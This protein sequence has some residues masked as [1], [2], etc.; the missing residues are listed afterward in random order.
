M[1]INLSAARSGPYINFNTGPSGT[2]GIRQLSLSS[3]TS[4]LAPQPPAPSDPGT[5]Q[6]TYTDND[7]NVFVWDPATSQFVPAAGGT[8]SSASSPAP[9]PAPSGPSVPYPGGPFPIKTPTP[10]PQTGGPPGGIGPVDPLAATGGHQPGELSS[11][12]LPSGYIQDRE[13]KKYADGSYNWVP[14]GSPHAPSAA[15]QP[16]TPRVD[17][18]AQTTSAGAAALNAQTAAQRAAAEAQAAQDA[19]QFKKDQAGIDNAYRDATQK[20]H[21]AI[22]ARDFAAAEHWKQVAADLNQ[23]QFDLNDR[24]Q[25]GNLRNQTTGLYGFDENGRPTLDTGRVTGY[26]RMPDGSVVSTLDRQLGEANSRRQDVAINLNRQQQAFNQEQAQREE[27]IKL[28]LNP[29]TALE[30]A[31]LHGKGGVV[32]PDTTFG[33]A[34]GRIQHTPSVEEFLNA[35][36]GYNPNAAQPAPATAATPPAAPPGAQQ[37]S[38]APAP[39]PV[40]AGVAPEP[41]IGGIPVSALGQQRDIPGSIAALAGA[42]AAPGGGVQLGNP[43]LNV[44][45]KPTPDMSLNS[46]APTSPGPTPGLS[47]ALQIPGNAGPGGTHWGVL[48]IGPSGTPIQIDPMANTG[49]R[50]DAAPVQR[51]GVITNNV[52]GRPT[53]GEVAGG[54]PASA[55][56]YGNPNFNGGIDLT[57]T[58]NVPP[59]TPTAGGNTIGNATV[60]APRQSGALTMDEYRAGLGG[61][62]GSPGLDAAYSAN[63]PTLGQYAFHPIGGV[64]QLPGQTQNALSSTDQQFQ[65][66]L[67]QH[68]GNA[69]NGSSADYM[70]INRR[71]GV[72]LSAPANR[73]V[74]VA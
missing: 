41:T 20:W 73:R 52:Y 54:A 6:P 68:T 56:G 17:S 35:Q 71:P 40:A 39:A 37:P 60:P 64:R 69:L 26:V 21:E 53:P 43:P 24:I 1:A 11:V 10:A 57:P 42:T 4:P 13:W 66:G 74:G 18:P 34:L 30:Y 65:Q 33:A 44:N 58:Q 63:R 15:N 45:I 14:I 51:P 2:P 48:S 7:G 50:P 31:Q 12:T 61:T 25:T 23:Q 29:L 9:T 47:P 19:A 70:D 55:Q 67:L 16:K 27:A 36:N 59:P 46:V 72:S 62:L 8:P 49:I 32:N 3:T 5:D 22:D 28:G 38:A